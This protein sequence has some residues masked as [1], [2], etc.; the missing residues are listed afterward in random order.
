MILTGRI[1]SIF[2][3]ANDDLESQNY[4][5]ILLKIKYQR[6]QTS[7]RH[8]IKHNHV[9]SLI[10]NNNCISVRHWHYNTSIG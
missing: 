3:H 6:M 9:K 1:W 8:M 5:Y 10:I 7:V 4:N 2:G